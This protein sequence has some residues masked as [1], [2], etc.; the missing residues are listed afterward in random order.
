MKYIIS[1]R[2]A[3]HDGYQTLDVVLY[4]NHELFHLAMSSGFFLL[5][6]VVL[7]HPT[8]HVLEQMS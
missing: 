5:A 6:Q 4:S 7:T 2:G 8:A 3:V 1:G